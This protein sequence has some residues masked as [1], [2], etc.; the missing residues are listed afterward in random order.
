[1]QNLHDFFSLNADSEENYEYTVSWIDCLAKGKQRGRGFFIRA[2]HTST[3]QKPVI[4]GKRFFNSI[5]ATLPISAINT[6]SLK[7][8]NTLYYHKQRQNRVKKQEQRDSFFYPLDNIQHWNRLYGR[9]GFLQY[10]CVVPKESAEDVIDALLQNIAAAKMGSFLVVLKAFGELPSKGLLSFAR[11]GITLAI[12][13]PQNGRRTFELLNALD[14]LI[15]QAGG[16]LY[17]AKDARMSGADFKTFFPAWQRFQQFKDP[18]LS[19]SFWRRVMKT[20]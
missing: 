5:P 19:S 14:K 1:M 4:R 2:N 18:E 8:F 17:P 12:D 10:Q 13:F 20:P 11:P 16:V 7:A 6:L 3:Q 9:R 15:K